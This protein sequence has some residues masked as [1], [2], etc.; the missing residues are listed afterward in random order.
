MFRNSRY[1]LNEQYSEYDPSL[2]AH[3][4]KVDDSSIKNGDS[5]ELIKNKYRKD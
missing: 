5:L 1:K 4:I 2:K 3:V